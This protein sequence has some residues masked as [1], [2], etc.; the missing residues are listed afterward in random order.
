ML[1]VLDNKPSKIGRCSWSR[2]GDTGERDKIHLHGG[3][4]FYFAAVL[5]VSANREG[6]KS[7]REQ[8]SGVRNL[9][10]KGSDSR[11]YHTMLGVLDDKPSKRCCLSVGQ[12]LAGPHNALKSVYTP[13]RVLH[14]NIE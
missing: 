13:Y 12:S 7:E 5:F 2:F 8:R 6:S 11:T 14:E 10:F 4:E 9:M 3:L 1:G